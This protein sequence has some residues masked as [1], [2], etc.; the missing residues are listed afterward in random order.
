MRNE[1]HKG[2]TD[3]RLFNAFKYAMHAG[4]C[5]EVA[6]VV[7]AQGAERKPV[8]TFVFA[9]PQA[10]RRAERTPLASNYKIDDA[11]FLDEL[12]MVIEVADMR[13]EKLEDLPKTLPR[14]FRDLH[15]ILENYKVPQYAQ[16]KDYGS[17]IKSIAAGDKQ[18]PIKYS[19]MKNIVTARDACSFVHTDDPMQP[20]EDAMRVLFNE[21]VPQKLPKSIDTILDGQSRFTVFGVPFM[22][23][24]LG[25]AL[26]EGGFASFRAKWLNLRM[27]PEEATVLFY[28]KSLKMAYPEGSPMHPS[29]PAMHSMA[30][31][32]QA[33]L[34]LEFFE[35]DFVMSHGETVEDY[36]MHLAD[37][38]GYF[39]VLA[40]V[41]Y[42]SDHTAYVPVA[43]AIAA[44]VAAPF[45]R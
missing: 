19:K 20:W 11:E 30:A 42:P 23:G 13:D 41:H 35:G 43:A 39:R 18:D 3:P 10:H 28:E 40:G 9:M 31:L 7:E 22:K 25:E 4:D 33:F 16:G 36:L 45:L 14:G 1:F 27:R 15:P 34:L 21:R 2:W 29:F 37:N 44:S 32:V 17:R 12:D 26:R 24:M 5:S 38:I 6:G 8:D